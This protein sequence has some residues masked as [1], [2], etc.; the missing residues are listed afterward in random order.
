MK[1]WPPS[2]R[3]AMK[4]TAV[5]PSG[6]TMTRLRSIPSC[7]QRDRKA[8]PNSSPPRR[9][10]YPQR[11]PMR[12]AATMKLAV[13]PPNPR[14]NVRAVPRRPRASAANSTIGSPTARI[15]GRR[16]DPS[17]LLHRLADGPEPP[18]GLG[19]L[20][21]RLLDLQGGGEHVRRR[22]PRNDDHPVRIADDDVA[23]MDEDA[24]THHGEVEPHGDVPTDGTAGDD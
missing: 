3:R 19:H 10:T 4:Y 22:R 11:A 21:L 17:K 9:V 8:R 13:S 6:S 20:A 24:T 18:D 15:S 2:S 7:S 23:G 5:V 16:S 12:E 14:R 1:S